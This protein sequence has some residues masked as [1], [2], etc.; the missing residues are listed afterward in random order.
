MGLKITG[1]VIWN[2]FCLAIFLSFM[3]I[4]LQL[5]VSCKD[6]YDVSFQFVS[7]AEGSVPH[8]FSHTGM[9]CIHITDDLGCHRAYC[10]TKDG[11]LAFPPADDCISEELSGVGLGG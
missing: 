4:A 11:W 10:W 5:G 8:I 9:W 2:L 1:S 7:H 3:F 6:D